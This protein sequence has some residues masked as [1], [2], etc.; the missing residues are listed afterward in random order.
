MEKPYS[1]HFAVLKLARLFLLKD[2]GIL[3]GSARQHAAAGIII[4][5]INHKKV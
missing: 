2:R 4:G 3:Q 1:C 5:G